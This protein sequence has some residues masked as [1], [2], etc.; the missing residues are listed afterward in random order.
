MDEE[1]EQ[2][3]TEE[4][5]VDE[6]QGDETEIDWK[7]MAR[8]H[9]KEAKRNRAAAEELEKLKQERMTESEKLAARAEK[10]E[11]ELSRITAEN[12]RVAAAQE[13]AK[14]TGIALELLMF[15]KDKDAMERFAEVYRET[16]HVPSAPKKQSSRIVRDSETP[17]STR[18]VF[19][20]MM[21]NLI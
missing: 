6:P 17:A 9:E 1:L 21:Q 10:A 20:E 14:T 15:C 8:K 16:S 2:Q 4:V 19:A 18:D 13:V 12:E 7:A 5:E 11:A 3:Q